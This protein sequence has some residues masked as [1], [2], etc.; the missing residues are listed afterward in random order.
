M[1]R[2]NQ[3]AMTEAQASQLC[4]TYGAEFRATKGNVD[5]WRLPDGTFLGVKKLGNGLA[6][7]R[8]VSAEACG[9]S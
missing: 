7:V 1:H 6:E 5:W 4:T 8:R 3:N 9:C 2:A